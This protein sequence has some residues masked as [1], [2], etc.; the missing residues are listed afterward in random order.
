M[1]KRKICIVITAR[2]SYSRIRSVLEAINKHPK[3]ELQVVVAA[4]ALLD[5]Y[6]N[7]TEYM[8]QDK[9]NI[10]SKVY[11]VMEGEDFTAMA[12]TTGIGI[13]EL[14]TVFDNLCPDIV[15]SVA[16][17]Y[18]TISTAITASFMNIPL[19]HIQGGEVTGNIDEKVRHSV[20]KLA[21]YHFVATKMAKERVLKLGESEDKIFLTGCPSIDIAK[22]VND[23]PE[24]DFN[25]FFKYGGVGK[26]FN[27]KNGYIVVMQHP[28]TNE[29]YQAGDQVEATLKAIESLGYPTFWFWP[30][31]DAGSNK[32][33]KAIRSFREENEVDKIHFIKSMSPEDF[34]KLL[35]NS[36]GIIGNS[37]VAIREC[38][39]LGIP[40]VNIGSRQSR[41]ERGN[42]VIDVD[43]NF[44]NIINAVEKNWEK[45]KCKRSNLYGKGNAGKKIV[46]LLAKIELVTEKQL[47]Y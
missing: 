21:D 4:S 10:S 26:Q 39:F 34:L 14:T 41:R 3:L 13:L 44:K 35:L 25:P 38:S 9:I 15:I 23:N 27:Y 19:V 43:Y 45:M 46:D 29:Y 2:P 18:E 16:D 20:T 24:L 17:R 36:R 40:A 42:N 32:T 33:S 5:M 7:I 12:K 8:K 47:T 37:S 22:K 31:V 6:G 11:M 28:V 30:N 1:K